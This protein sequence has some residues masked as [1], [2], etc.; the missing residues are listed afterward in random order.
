MDNERDALDR[1]FTE[2]FSNW[3]TIEASQELLDFQDAG[4]R[5]LAVEMETLRVRILEDETSRLHA[6][7]STAHAES[8]IIVA[9]AR[10]QEA[11]NEAVR[12]KGENTQQATI[13]VSCGYCSAELDC[14]G[15][16]EDHLENIHAKFVDEH[17][18]C[19]S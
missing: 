14:S 2:R 7:A 18:Y 6:K 4:D 1:R 17:G 9:K 13:K 5:L 8:D 12:L 3:G 11:M 10:L 16:D 15:F 19:R